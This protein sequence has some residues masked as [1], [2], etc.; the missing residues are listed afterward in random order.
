MDEDLLLARLGERIDDAHRCPVATAE[1]VKS[2]AQ[3]TGLA[4]PPFYTRLLT[5]V[6]NGGFG[7]GFGLIGIP[8]YFDDE[9][10]SDLSEAY[11]EGRGSHDPALR[12]PDGLLYLCSWG[13]GVHSYVDCSSAVGAVVTDELLFGDQV[14]FTE[15][16]PALSIWLAD[17]LSGIDL[18]T[19]MHRI[20]GYRE[21]IN[22][23]T[24]QPIKLPMRERVGR[25]LDM[26]DRR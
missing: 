21:G 26:R 13:C 22:P 17:W 7:P 5:E 9:L 1:D 14:E 24:K 23:F 10:R 25:R 18:E 8:P 19:A 11:L 12:N 4:L 20:V 2:F 16:S 15:T 6:A 3:A